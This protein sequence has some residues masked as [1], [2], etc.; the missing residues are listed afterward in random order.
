MFEIPG[1]MISIEL[2]IDMFQNVSKDTDW[3]LSQPMVWGY[4]FS[5]HE[6]QK[7]EEVNDILVRREYRCIG[8]YLCTKEKPDDP[9]SYCLHVEKIETHTPSTLDQRNNEFYILAHEQGLTYDGMD[10]GPVLN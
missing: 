8:I 1:K 4:F 5:N 7:L 6:P 2:L 10:I 3:D 9:D